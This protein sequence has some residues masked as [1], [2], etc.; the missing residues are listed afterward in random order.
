MNHRSFWSC[1]HTY[2]IIIGEDDREKMK[3]IANEID[4]I[5]DNK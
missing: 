4:I 3:N 1:R 5:K 2:T